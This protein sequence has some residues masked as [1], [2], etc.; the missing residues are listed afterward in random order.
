MFIATRV[1][2]IGTR[3]LWADECGQA[4][5]AAS[6]SL[7]EMYDRAL[8]WDRHPPLF[9]LGVFAIAKLGNSELMLRSLSL[10]SGL[11][12]L[13]LGYGMA[14]Q[15]LERFGAVAF[16]L[17]SG[18]APAMAFYSREARPY[19]LA[20]LILTVFL[21]ALGRHLSSP[22]KSTTTGLV[23][24]AVLGALTLYAA[25]FII[26]ACLCAA[27]V[28]RGKRPPKFRVDPGLWLS[29][30][31]L[32]ICNVFLALTFLSKYQGLESTSAM[33]VKLP[34]NASLFES[35][36]YSFTQTVELFGYIALGEIF[37]TRW[38]MAL[39]AIGCLLLALLAAEAIRAFRSEPRVRILLVALTGVLCGLLVLS[40]L[41]LHP[42]GPGRH[43]LVVA[44]LVF[45]CVAAALEHLHRAMPAVAI[46]LL[47][48]LLLMGLAS[49]YRSITP[50]YYIE[51]LPGALQE[52]SLSMTP[53]DILIVPEHSLLSFEYYKDRF[54]LSGMQVFTPVTDEPP[55]RRAEQFLAAVPADSRCWLLLTHYTTA[56]MRAAEEM[57]SRAWSKGQ[58]IT[59]QGAE[60][61]HWT[62][63]V[64]AISVSHHAPE[65][66]PAL[67]IVP[68]PASAH[69]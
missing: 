45:L 34:E 46:T 3:A 37:G 21:Y 19:A 56:D 7:G 30:G 69:P 65:N 20:L 53:K 47:A 28:A 59:R 41:R 44:P 9:S 6:D 26:G 48:S 67:G 15:W 55:E 24:T 57:L 25:T 10:A 12:T 54:A 63:A 4:W 40:L 18:A 16:A 2:D 43:C 49:S 33:Y 61:S 35:A 68:I 29:L 36:T 52:A 32:V 42:F 14:R 13:L 64:A 17:L 11:A 39:Y 1:G 38:G 60:I 31:G 22:S 23:L 62:P 66:L 58:R 50:N 8:Q 5:L 27:L 51:D